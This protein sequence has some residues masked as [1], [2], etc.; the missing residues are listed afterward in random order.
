MIFIVKFQHDLLIR[1]KIQ[2]WNFIAIFKNLKSDT[3]IKMC[4][5]IEPSSVP[6]S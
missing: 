4:R 3:Y 5:V 1:G 6:G 2:R